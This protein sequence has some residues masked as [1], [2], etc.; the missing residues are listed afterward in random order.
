MDKEFITMK[1]NEIIPYENNPRYN[2]EAV[3]YVV[4]SIKTFGFRVPII[5]DKNRCIVAGHTRYAAAK[6]LGM[7]ELPCILASE[8]SENQ[9]RAFRIIDN[10]T[11][12]LSSWDFSKLMTELDDIDEFDMSLYGF[13][14]DNAE[15]KE[16]NE[17]ESEYSGK[18]S[19]LDEGKE[20]DLSSFDEEELNCV[21]PHCGFRFIE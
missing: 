12:S 3:D 7:K 14:K 1:L 4:N 8:L 17:E 21:C 15:D 16:R 13:S 18:T 19:N 2:D 9:I 6:K 20:L 11:Q 5:I 10:Q